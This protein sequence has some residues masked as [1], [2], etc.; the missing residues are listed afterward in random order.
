MSSWLILN[1]LTVLSI[2]LSFPFEYL[3][4]NNA[5]GP[6][7]VDSQWRGAADHQ[8]LH[9]QI[10]LEKPWVIVIHLKETTRMYQ[11]LQVRRFPAYHGALMQTSDEP[12]A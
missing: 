1:N 8:E 9:K 7:M 6:V 12:M 3:M 4:S 2:S 5:S 11:V 10:Q